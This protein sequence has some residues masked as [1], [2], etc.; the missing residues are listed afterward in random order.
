LSN[1]TASNLNHLVGLTSA[2]RLILRLV[3]GEDGPHAVLLYGVPGSGK[4][5]LANLL[6][7]GWL[8]QEPGAEGADGTCRACIAY[9]RGN[10]A[11]FLRVAPTGA[12]R[13]IVVK[14]ISNS[15]IKNDDPTPVTTYV[16]TLPMMARH[17][18]ILIEDAHRMNGAAASALL[19]TLEEPHPHAKLILTTDSVG[20]I[21]PT[22]LSRCLAVACELP[23]RDELKSLAPTASPDVIRMADGAPGRVIA[24][25]TNPQIYERMAA[26][27]RSLPHRPAGAALVCSEEFKAIADAL[28]AQHSSGARTA[29]A[30]ALELLAVFLA[31]EPNTPPSWTQAAIEAH[32]R[33]LGNVN[34]QFAYDALFAQMLTE[35]I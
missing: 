22:I 24:G 34:S 1:S 32:R 18:V 29:N 26:F 23:S 9:E 19:K 4:Q 13:I 25:A 28:A 6:A 2:K 14:A 10:C 3:S 30:L 7:Q 11:D 21:L 33:V 17:K 5:E 35:A 27:A 31:R 8:C 15:E 20:S 12:S 16:R